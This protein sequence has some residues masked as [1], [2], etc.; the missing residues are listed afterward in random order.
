VPIDSAVR[1]ILRDIE[2]APPGV[3]PSAIDQLNS[4]QALQSLGY[5]RTALTYFVAGT[6]AEGC[7]NLILEPDGFANE[8]HQMLEA[9]RVSQIVDFGSLLVASM[10]RDGLLWPSFLAGFLMD[11]G[12]WRRATTSSR[13]GL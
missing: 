12:T 2:G 8:T 7:D 13:S 1:V 9:A 10:S 5:W 11:C 6:A 4:A 3:S